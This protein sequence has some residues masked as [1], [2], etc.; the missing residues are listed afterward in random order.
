MSCNAEL[1]GW[2][3]TVDCYQEVKNA[4]RREFA[5]VVNGGCLDSAPTCNPVCSPESPDPLRSEECREGIRAHVTS[6]TTL[7]PG[8]TEYLA[9]SCKLPN[10]IAYGNDLCGGFSIHFDNIKPE[11]WPCLN[12]QPGLGFH[13]TCEGTPSERPLVS[14]TRVQRPVSASQ[15]RTVLSSAADRSHWPVG[16]TEMERTRPSCPEKS[17]Y[18]HG[19]RG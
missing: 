10:S 15:S 7:L 14:H 1:S 2:P 12:Q 17:R 18:G 13:A 3:S 9:R 8:A 11:F 4:Q 16:D 5:D 19:A 6:D